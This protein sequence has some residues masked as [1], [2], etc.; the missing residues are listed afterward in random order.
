MMMYRKY[1]AGLFLLML[2]QTSNAGQCL[3]RGGWLNISTSGTTSYITVNVAA[4]PGSGYVLLEG[5]TLYCRFTPNSSMSSSARDYWRTDINPI[6]PGPKFGSYPIGL[7]INN[8]FYNTPTSGLL[9]AS[10]A[11]QELSGRDLATYMF[12]RTVGVP[13]S[14]ID[15]RA[16][17]VLGT[18]RLVQTNN[19]DSTSPRLSIQFRAGNNLF[20]EPSTCTI[21][22]NNPIEVDFMDVDPN[23]IGESPGGSP[24]KKTLSLNYACPD[25][26]I[27]S[28]ITIT[29]RG[30]GALFNSQILA[31]S[32]PGLGVALLKGGAVV[33]PGGYFLSS[34]T[35]S[36]GADN[37]TFALVRNSGALPGSGVFTGSATL[38]MGVP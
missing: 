12:I 14:Y 6:I 15:I 16:G 7:R 5:Y 29:L 3:I 9:I 38:V 13:G 36:V 32:N 10:M 22:N 30:S 37:V 11:N 4:V 18:L 25:P 28:A 8:V 34:I 2:M 1:L 26:N 24:V 20:F 35:N 23:V 17:D 33:R 31:T 27:N 19:Y 21:N